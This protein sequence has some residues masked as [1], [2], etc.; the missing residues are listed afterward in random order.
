MMQRM[1]HMADNKTPIFVYAVD[2]IDH[3]AGWHRVDG[4]F[5]DRVGMI[6]D[7]TGS[8]VERMIAAVD[9]ARRVQ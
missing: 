4:M 3:W 8:D 6:F 9:A 5:D 2:P 7:R 1:A